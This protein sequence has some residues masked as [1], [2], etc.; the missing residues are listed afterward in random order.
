MSNTRSFGVLPVAS[1]PKNIG[2]ARPVHN[3]GLVDARR[4]YGG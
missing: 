4:N 1:G 2:E 3:S